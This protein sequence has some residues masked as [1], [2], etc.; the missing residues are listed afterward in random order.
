[1]PP[2]AERLLFEAAHSYGQAE[3][4]LAHL[5]EARRLAPDH[6]AV[7]IG[8]YRFFFYKGRLNEAL[9]IAR[10]CLL[11]AA[12]D[13]SLPLDWRRVRPEQA[14]FASFDA[15]MA[16]FFMFV[17][18]GYAYLQHATWRPG[19]RS[20]GDR[21]A[22]RTRSLRQDGRAGAAWRVASKGSKAMSTEI[23]EALD[24]LGDAVD[25]GGCPHAAL[26]ARQRCQP[27]RACVFDRYARR[28]DRF[29]DWNPASRYVICTIPIS[30]CAPAPPR[31]RIFSIC[32]RCSPTRRK[33]CAGAPRGG[34]R[35]AISCACAT[36]PHREVRIRVAQ[37]LEGA[38][39]LRA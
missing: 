18:K 8:L 35:R 31:P 19:G 9:E 6:P 17:L 13:N 29:F 2:E 1:M 25:C 22:S 24:W 33:P 23:D 37:R 32:R 38:D 11:R 4:A 12:I 27:L 15:P 7:L 34:C 10:T 16:R 5:R 14:A 21:K 30:R 36:D 26:L 20:R 3:T 39:D 28:I